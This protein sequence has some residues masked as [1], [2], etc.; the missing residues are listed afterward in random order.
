[1]ATF[2]NSSATASAETQA[3]HP[4]R[5]WILGA[6]AL[7]MLVVGLD[8]T[9]LNVALSDISRALG[10]STTDLQWIVNGYTLTS[11]VLLI[12]AGMLG[13]RY[14]RRTV[15]A[16]GLAVF[17]A[18]SALGAFAATPAELVAARTVMGIGA[19]A[20]FPLSMSILPTVFAPG[21]RAKAVAVITA[22]MG[23]GMPLG[24]LLG[25][26][27]LDNYW[28]GSTLLI[29]VPTVA[30]ALATGLTL[31]PNSKDS[32]RRRFDL[33][34]MLL[35]VAGLAGIVYGITQEPVSG[36]G[37][38]EVLVPLIGGAGLLVAFWFVERRAAAPLLD[39]R[40]TGNRM[41][42][43]PTIATALTSFVMMG[44]LFA[45]PLYLQAFLGDSAL[46]T[47]VKLLPMMLALVVGAAVGTRT[48]ALVGLRVVVP[49][50]ILISAAG[51][52]AL[53][54]LVPDS[55]YWPLLAA[56]AATGLGFG[57]AM[58]PATT[59]MLD[60][61]PD[62]IQSTGTAV[63]LAVKQTVGALGVAIL[64]SVLTAVYRGGMDAATAHL[65]AAAADAAH[66]S[67]GGAVAVA[68]RL[69]PAGNALKAAAGS[70]YLDGVHVVSVVCIAAAVLIAVVMAAVLPGRARGEHTASSAQ[71]APIR[72]DKM[73]T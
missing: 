69:G 56:L 17:V 44:L 9:V 15:L 35:T 54:R 22:A 63:N 5:W 3:G 31:I 33:A 45:L 36:W 52:A 18:A 30:I 61:L 6:L 11:A 28:W 57:I 32:G 7:T 29:N 55:D 65:P 72:A 53:L 38:G 48:T 26:W 12:P 70:A 68:S 23:L 13:D 47:G 25:G 43:W 62:G 2:K 24:P 4:R 58:P 59:A 40:L 21:E 1:M 16:V 10:A 34:G 64:G 20:V 8:A 39:P 14:G 60:S 19:A 27:L 49:A 46:V 51:F 42:V 71:P 50:G 37:S 41:F 67:I 66:D 73:N